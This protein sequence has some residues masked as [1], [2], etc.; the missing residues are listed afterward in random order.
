MKTKQNSIK[1]SPRSHQP[2]SRRKADVSFFE[3]AN[4]AKRILKL[5]ADG[6][7]AEAK[8]LI[9][10]AIEEPF[11]KIMEFY[12]NLGYE[13]RKLEEQNERDNE[14]TFGEDYEKD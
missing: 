13:T 9:S 8:A 11:K 6:K 4:I 3:D 10:L 12:T 7:E 14:L 1:S 5:T 2:R